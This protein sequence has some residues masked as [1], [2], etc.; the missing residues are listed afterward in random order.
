VSDPKARL[1]IV[2]GPAPAA[3]RPAPPA[4]GAERG[5]ADLRDEDL[6]PLL[7][8]FYDTVERDEL[9]APYFAPVDMS[10]HMPRIVDFWST[11]VFDTRRYTGN[12]FRPHMEMPGLTAAHF[13]R[14]VATMEATIDARHAGER[15]ERMKALAH[16]IA[17]SMQLRLGIEPFAAFRA[18]P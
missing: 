12:A 7:V 14:W 10:A 18:L 4:P 8:A 3:E 17:Y 2:D 1:P 6:H 15:A 13:A 5:T 9:L 11:L 16:R